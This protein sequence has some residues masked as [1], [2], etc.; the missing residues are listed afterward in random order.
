MLGFTS[1]RKEE[2]MV[3]KD[4]KLKAST[5]K[6]SFELPKQLSGRTNPTNMV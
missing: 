1:I 6:I 3:L 4:L 2:K 5:N